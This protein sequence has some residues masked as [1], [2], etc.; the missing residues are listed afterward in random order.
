[1]YVCLY[2]CMYICMFVCMYVYI[3]V[4]RSV[5]QTALSSTY[6]IALPFIL[7]N[8]S[9]FVGH[10]CSGGSLILDCRGEEAESSQNVIDIDWKAT[11]FAESACSDATCCPRTE[12]C[13]VL[14]TNTSHYE[15]DHGEELKACN[16]KTRCEV[17][18][19]KVERMFDC[20]SET[21]YENVTYRCVPPE[22]PSTGNVIVT[23]DTS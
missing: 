14:V 13:T 20:E 5:S 15:S 23:I 3:H 19:E 1:M 10:D 7:S 18:V 12:D 2:A 22:I 11:F 8:I 6:R 21:D 4:C 16:G 9:E 17:T